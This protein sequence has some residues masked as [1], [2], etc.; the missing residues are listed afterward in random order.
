MIPTSIEVWN[1]EVAAPVIVNGDQWI[2]Y[3]DKDSIITKV[4]Q[5]IVIIVLLKTK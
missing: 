3:D 5:I 1:D 2:A 4:G